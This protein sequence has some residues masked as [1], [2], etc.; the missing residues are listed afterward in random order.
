G[1]KAT[2]RQLHTVLPVA[3]VRQPSDVVKPLGRGHRRDLV[4][5]ADLQDLWNGGLSADICEKVAP[6]HEESRSECVGLPF[7]LPTLCAP[8][9]RR[10]SRMHSQM[11][12]LMCQIKSRSL[13][14]LGG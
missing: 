12:Q 1:A 10:Y 9:P 13:C 5:A 2:L 8:G 3:P 14:G 4:I 6:G 7:E 11:A